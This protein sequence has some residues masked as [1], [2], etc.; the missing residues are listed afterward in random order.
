MAETDC[1]PQVQACA[2]RVARLDT[3]G[4]PLPGANNLYVSDALVELNWTSVYVDGDEIEDK[5]ACGI[6]VVNYRGRDSFKRGDV[7][8]KLVT[9][10]PFL[11]EM[12]SGGSVLTSGSVPKGFAAPPIGPVTGNGVSIELWAIRVDDGDQDANYP[13]AHWVYPKVKNLRLGDHSHANASIQPVFT[14]QAVENPNW[15]D[16]PVGDWPATSDRAYQWLP[17]STI[18]TPSCAYQTLAAS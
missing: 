14:G 10:D 18:P 15:F 7:E 13:Y 3:N 8:V 9:P 1:R 6:V 17:T 12:L 5:N 16:G 2:I 4:V 11:S